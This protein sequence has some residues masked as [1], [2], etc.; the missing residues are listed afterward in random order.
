VLL[1]ETDVKGALVVAEQIRHAV[2]H[3][4]IRRFDSDEQIGGIS[5]SI[6]IASHSKGSDLLALLDQADKALYTSKQS[7]RNR[8][9]IFGQQ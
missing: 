9:S 7:G 5:I 6:G 8:T 4:K 1:P 3:G 2:E